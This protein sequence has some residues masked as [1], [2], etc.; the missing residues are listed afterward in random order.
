LGQL[1]HYLNNDLAPGLALL[2]LINGV[3][4]AGTVVHLIRHGSSL[5]ILEFISLMLTAGLWIFIVFFPMTQVGKIKI[6]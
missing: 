2:L 1:L 6:F 5:P 4:A 3:Y